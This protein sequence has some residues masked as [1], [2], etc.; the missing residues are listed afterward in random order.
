[1]AAHLQ[2]LRPSVS[3]LSNDEIARLDV[4][5]STKRGDVLVVF[6]YRRYDPALR[7]LAEA[8]AARDGR[9]VLFTDPGLS[10]IVASASDVVTSDS[11]PGH[12]RLPRA[13]DGRRGGVGDEP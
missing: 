4:L 8:F 10:P 2:M 12:L 5:A 3:L 11:P 13:S 1:M 6:D 9:V 7:D